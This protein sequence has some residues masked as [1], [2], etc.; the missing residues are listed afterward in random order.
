MFIS[1]H[2]HPTKSFVFDDTFG[3]AQCH[4]ISALKLA[5]KSLQYVH[6]A[7][8]AQCPDGKRPNP[9]LPGVQGLWLLRSALGDVAFSII[10]MSQ[11]PKQP[12]CGVEWVLVRTIAPVLLFDISTTTLCI[13]LNAESLTVH[14]LHKTFLFLSI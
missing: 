9:P 8:T 2:L 12:N 14:F 5:P 10:T 6:N 7:V 1:C 11:V 3:I 4:F 13:V